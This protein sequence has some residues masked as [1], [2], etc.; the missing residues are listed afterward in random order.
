[1]VS[2]VKDSFITRLFGK[3]SDKVR[4]RY[5]EPE[6]EPSGLDFSNPNPTLL[7]AFKGN[8][9]LNALMGL[10]GLQLEETPVQQPQQQRQ[11]RYQLYQLLQPEPTRDTA[12]EDIIRKR[13]KVNAIGKGIS[14]LS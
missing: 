10:Q 6:F 7:D 2:D 11:S 8:Q 5:L 12:S 4:Q 3:P 1:M 13:A 14:C 9:S